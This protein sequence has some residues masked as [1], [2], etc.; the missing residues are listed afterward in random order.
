M[1]KEA[2]HNTSHADQTFQI[3]LLINLQSSSLIIWAVAEED[4]VGYEHDSNI[5]AD[6][7]RFSWMVPQAPISTSQGF[8]HMG[9][10]DGLSSCHVVVHVCHYKKAQADKAQAKSSLNDGSLLDLDGHK[11]NIYKH[12]YTN[13]HLNEMSFLFLS[14]KLGLGGSQIRSHQSSASRSD[15]IEKI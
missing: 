3:G 11:L 6:M 9:L 8:G 10:Q 2:G 15:P 14:P 1:I 13:V 12:I 4:V 7:S 5:I